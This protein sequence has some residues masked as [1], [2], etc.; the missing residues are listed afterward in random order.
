[1]PEHSLKAA[2]VVLG[3][4][5]RISRW[6]QIL[7]EIATETDKSGPE[8]VSIPEAK[9]NASDVTSSTKVTIDIGHVWHITI[10]HNCTRNFWVAGR[11]IDN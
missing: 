2:G 8:V 4:G 3:E 6:A 10:A 11:N 9:V 1:M 5:F 7:A